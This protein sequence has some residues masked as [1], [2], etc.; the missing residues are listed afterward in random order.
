[1]DY[2]ATEFLPLSELPAG[3]AEL[4]RT[5]FGSG[6]DATWADLGTQH[7]DRA[8][9]LLAVCGALSRTILDLGGGRSV[10]G[11]AMIS[12]IG[13][14]SGDRV[15][16]LL[17]RVAFGSWRDSGGRFAITRADGTVE[18]G[19]VGFNRG[20]MGGSLHEGFDIQGITGNRDVPR[21]QWNYRHCDGLAD[22]DVDGYSPWDV[23]HHLSYANS[24][25]RQW[26]AKYV[27]KF[28]QAPF[29]VN[30]VGGVEP[31][32]VRT[33]SQCPLPQDRLSDSER[34][35]AAE[36]ALAFSQVLEATRDF[37]AAVDTFADRDL[38]EETLRSPQA[39]PL[40]GIVAPAVLEQAPS[41]ALRDYYLARSNVQLNQ[42]DMSDGL[43]R[44]AGIRS[45]A[46][47]AT[48]PT[49]A[50]LSVA[51]NA[52]AS[53]LA[54][55]VES[56]D[57]LTRANRSLRADEQR[58][59]GLRAEMARVGAA[60]RETAP[61]EPAVW[62]TTDPAVPRIAR[63][64]AVELPSVRLILVPDDSDFRVVSAVPWRSPLGA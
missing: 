5:H 19:R 6:A 2:V 3:T 55:P 22:I 9:A 27:S 14:L 25:A 60:A 13:M 56:V 50:A 45:S 28:G 51:V 29:R 35:R 37:R 59:S 23:F 52:S 47:A 12:E 4:T 39:S 26:Y 33:T 31:D 18:S 11:L 49:I 21:I 61:P 20:G 1:M 36:R 40:I 17:D 38:F 42:I 32:V 24:D 41:E 15:Y 64:V 10:T 57:E 34:R 7:D 53:A 48:D 62:L 46:E 63:A 44:A 43:R 30:R 58:T 54:E 8:A 16:V